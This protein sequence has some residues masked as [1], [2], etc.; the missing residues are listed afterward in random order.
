MQEGLGMNAAQ[1]GA[2]SLAALPGVIREAIEA[3][4][5]VE[6]WNRLVA[7]EADI[8]AKGLLFT[9]KFR[10]VQKRVRMRALTREPRFETFDYPKPGLKSILIGEEEVR[11]EK[12]DG[13]VLARREHPRE[14]FRGLRRNFYWDRLDFAYFGSYATWNYLTTP[15]LFLRGGFTFEALDPLPRMPS[16]WSRFRVRFP[17]DIPTHCRCQ[18][19]IFDEE[20]LLRRL[21]Y[22]AEVVGGWAHAAHL[23]EG[24]RNFGGFM[25][26]TR[27]RVRPILFGSAPLAGPDLVALEFH[28]VRPIAGD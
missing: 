13:E 11:I 2:E 15:F 17:E 24:Y 25:I 20:R 14:G 8:S 9:L 27:R 26:P 23:C 5:G 6:R 1:M 7:L 18:E 3:H 19:F 16:G 21:D 4:G 28:D 10:P 22:T 12:A